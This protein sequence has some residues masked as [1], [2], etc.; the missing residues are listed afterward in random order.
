MQSG[1]LLRYGD[2]IGNMFNGLDLKELENFAKQYC[3][4]WD[5]MV[6]MNIG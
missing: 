4:T 2:S 6:T 1:L 3:T 5:Q